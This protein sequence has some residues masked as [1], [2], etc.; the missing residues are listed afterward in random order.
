MASKL[1]AAL[2]LPLTALHLLTGCV[3]RPKPA[4]TAPVRVVVIGGMVMTG[5][6]QEISTAFHQRTGLTIELAATGPKEILDTEFRKGGIDLITLHSSDVATNLAADGLASNIRPWARNE[7]VIVGPQNDPAQIRGMRS[8]TEALKKIAAKKAPF[9][10]ARNTG[11][12][13]VTIHLWRLAGI[14]PQGS[15]LI[16]DES[17][18]RQQVV[19]FAASR[20][21]YVI[22][23]RIPVLQGKIPSTGMEIM[24]EGDPEMRRPYVVLEAVPWRCH[25]SNPEG[26]RQMA[27]FLVSH[28]AQTIVRNFALSQTASNR[29]VFFPVDDNPTPPR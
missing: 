13:T 14:Q 18:S 27:D 3:N 5:L 19:Q 12:Q 6:W 7:L 16:K 15:W 8:G 10:E 23:G 17:E 24:V 22:V 9:V 25:N 2:L 21:A 28:E 29:P 1:I 26:A 4:N 20:H 11:S